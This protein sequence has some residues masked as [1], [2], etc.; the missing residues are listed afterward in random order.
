MENEIIM[1]SDLRTTCASLT[2]TIEFKGNAILRAG[3]ETDSENATG[4]K[5]L[6]ELRYGRRQ[7]RG[8]GAGNIK[9]KSIRQQCST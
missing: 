1:F 3:P 6:G 7:T 2:T 5:K 9:E 8:E 4:K